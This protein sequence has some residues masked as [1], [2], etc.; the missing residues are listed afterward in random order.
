MLGETPESAA[1]LVTLLD[2][3]ARALQEG[4]ADGTLAM[5]MKHM[6]ATMPSDDQDAAVMRIREQL[7]SVVLDIAGQL[8]TT[9]GLK[10]P[11]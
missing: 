9:S 6:G 2:Q 5:A 1:Q 10:N 11:G 4:T 7:A 3:A 8:E